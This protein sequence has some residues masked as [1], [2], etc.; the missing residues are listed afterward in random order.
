MPTSTLTNNKTDT[1]AIASLTDLIDSLESV[2][3]VSF[4]D[5]MCIANVLMQIDKSKLRVHQSLI[6]TALILFGNGIDKQS[7]EVFESLYQEIN[8]WVID[9]KVMTHMKRS[10]VLGAL[11][12]QA[13]G[14]SPTQK[15][16]DEAEAS[17]YVD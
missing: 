5:K 3:G 4:S 16:L 17:F 15:Q 10:S 2:E 11:T 9:T 6:Q 14:K 7:I 1:K 13:F 8:K 12:G